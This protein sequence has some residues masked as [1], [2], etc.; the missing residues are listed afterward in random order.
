[1]AITTISLEQNCFGCQGGSLLVLHRDGSALLTTTG[2]ARQGTADKVTTG[3]V[4]PADFD[5]LA[6]LVAAQGFFDLKDSYEDPQL[7]DG[8]WSTTT[9]S[10]G[11]SE[12]RV[13][14]RNES[15]PA[16][17]KVVEAAL[18]EMK[19]HIDFKP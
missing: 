3:H 18:E 7:R 11:T 17:L 1:M 13:F 8:A 10:R 5:K 16:S 9:V 12:K 15:G 14:R 6:R 2:S 19:S 4:A